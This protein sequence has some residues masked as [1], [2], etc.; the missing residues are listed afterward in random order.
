MTK[1]TEIY[2]TG[3]YIVTGVFMFLIGSFFG[4]RSGY[5]KGTNDVLDHVT[6]VLHKGVEMPDSCVLG[7]WVLFCEGD[8][9]GYNIIRK[10]R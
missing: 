4:F 5:E 3:L 6:N 10:P 9:I 1:K 2:V 8:T 7:Q